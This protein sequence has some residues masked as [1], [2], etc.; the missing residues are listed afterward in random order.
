MIV[1]K[2]LIYKFTF[3]NQTYIKSFLRRYGTLSQVYI[4]KHI[5]AFKDPSE[6]KQACWDYTVMRYGKKCF[7]IELLETVN[8][9]SKLKQTYSTFY[10]IYSKDIFK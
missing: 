7:K 5:E 3:N 6:D 1:T 10:S 8:D 4:S 2:G 9:L